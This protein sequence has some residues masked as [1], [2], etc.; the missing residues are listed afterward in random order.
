MSRF[1]QTVSLAHLVADDTQSAAAM[2]YVGAK[3][4][5]RKF[6]V[7]PWNLIGVFMSRQQKRIYEF[8]TYRLDAAERLLL[9]EGKVV[10]LQPKA[11]DLL[12]VLFKHHG[13]LQE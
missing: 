10:P 12:L 1:L 3:D 7:R 8:S 9:R 5:L 2:S 6:Q 4:F 13:R 11:F